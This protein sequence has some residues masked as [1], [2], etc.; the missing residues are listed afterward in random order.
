MADFDPRGSLIV[1]LSGPGPDTNGIAAYD[2]GR[3]LI[4]T[5]KMLGAVASFEIGREE[6]EF[7]DLRRMLDRIPPFV[8]RRL[9]ESHFIETR[10]G[11]LEVVLGVAVLDE[12]CREFHNGQLATAFL[13]NVFA[14]FFNSIVIAA[15]RSIRER[16]RGNETRPKLIAHEKH[17]DEVLASRVHPDLVHL[18]TKMGRKTG[19]EKIRLRAH[20]RSNQIDY[21]LEITL[22]D[23]RQILLYADKKVSPASEYRGFLRALNLEDRDGVLVDSYSGN[24]FHLE[25]PLDEVCQ[26]L[27]SHLNQELVLM[28]SVR[29]RRNVEDNRLRDSLLVHSV[30][31]V[32]PSTSRDSA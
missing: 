23:Q 32:R 28:A 17:D 12:I 2:L 20:V 15:G 27:A 19:I 16:F 13:T 7:R 1:T 24:R 26:E 22:R 29:T 10:R 30:K 3:I 5:Q 9:V 31:S 11:S 25:I 21:D 4:S 6:S 8:R 18:V 14:G